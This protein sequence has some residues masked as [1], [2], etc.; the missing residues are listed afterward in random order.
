METFYDGKRFCKHTETEQ[1]IGSGETPPS[2]PMDVRDKDGIYIVR[3]KIQSVLPRFDSDAY[4]AI[5]AE[6]LGMWSHVCG[7]E[8]IEDDA[9]GWGGIEFGLYPQPQPGGVL[10]D[11]M[12]PWD[13]GP[14]SRSKMTGREWLPLRMDPAERWSN[15]H[16]P[17]ADYVDP[18]RV[19]G[20]EGGHGIGISHIDEGNLMAP[21]YSVKIKGPQIGDIRQAVARYGEPRAKRIPTQPRTDRAFR[22][23]CKLLSEAHQIVI[24]NTD[25]S[26]VI[27]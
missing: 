7:I 17:R 9:I 19:I 13:K 21:M 22:D 10:A 6:G 1:L 4:R 23:V 26:E 24:R 8:F 25:G 27:L 16:N 14:N 11:C 5:I 20:H 18:V 3:Y 15:S 2:W 12:L